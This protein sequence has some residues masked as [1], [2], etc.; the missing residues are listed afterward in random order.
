MFAKD[1]RWGK[2]AVGVGSLIGDGAENGLQNVV[3]GLMSVAPDVDV[4]R[5][6][7]VSGGLG[8]EFSRLIHL[9]NY[10]GGCGKSLAG[11]TTCPT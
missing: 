1:D 6:D 7:T 8:A 2:G 10:G 4:G 11:E 5:L 9:F 3:G